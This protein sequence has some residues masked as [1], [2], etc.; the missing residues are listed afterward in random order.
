MI[1]PKSGRNA[2][3]AEFKFGGLLR[4][5]I[6]KI[7]LYAIL[8]DIKMAVLFATAKSPNLNH[9]QYVFPDLRYVY[10]YKNNY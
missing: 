8:T 2:L 1:Y 6:A 10:I 4:Y 5:I 7:S 3:L 9:R